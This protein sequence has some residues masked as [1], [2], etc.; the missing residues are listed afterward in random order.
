MYCTLFQPD[1]LRG[2]N[3]VV[4]TNTIAKKKSRVKEQSRKPARTIIIVKTH[5]VY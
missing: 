4:I 5:S 3:A 1:K 2:K